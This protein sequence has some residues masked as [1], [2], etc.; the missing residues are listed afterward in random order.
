M[1]SPARPVRFEFFLAAAALAVLLISASSLVLAVGGALLLAATLGIAYRRAALSDHDA[2]QRLATLGEVQEDAERRAAEAAR[3]RDEARA[4]VEEARAGGERHR[5]EAQAAQA[6]LEQERL[7]SD[8]LADRPIGYSADQFERLRDLAATEGRRTSADDARGALRRITATLELLGETSDT[9]DSGAQDTL[10]AAASARVRVE[11]AVRGSLALRETTSAAAEVTREIS[12]VADTTRLLA[13]NAAIEAARAGDQGRGFAVVADEV[14]KLAHAAGAAA[15]RVLA[16]INNVSSESAGV[17]ASIEATSASLEAVDAA[18][19]RIDEAV[20]AQRE[21][22]EQSQTTLAEATDRLVQLSERRSAARLDLE[23]RVLA[24]LQDG[25][26]RE[27]VE[28]VTVDLSAGGA[29]LQ[30]RPELGL[31]PWSLQILLPGYP[32][33]VQCTATLVR[34]LPGKLAVT[35]TEIAAMDLLALGDTVSGRAFSAPRF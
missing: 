29:L 7:R 5:R 18:T 10:H 31:G 8:A 25:S 26:A 21:A 23:T 30:G 22:T 15:Q 4:A 14:G 3:E 28:T 35:F 32:E 34:E 24:T 27:P 16:H 2:D 17:A 19:R 13:L 9:I 33:P 12:G 1:P 11:E 6:A 20:S